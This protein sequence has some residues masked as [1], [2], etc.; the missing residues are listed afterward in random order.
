METKIDN[1]HYSSHGEIPIKLLANTLST[2]VQAKG[3]DITL[4]GRVSNLTAI[5]VDKKGDVFFFNIIG[6]KKFSIQQK[7]YMMTQYHLL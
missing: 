6:F 4:T 2:M 3:V 1:R 7:S 5:P